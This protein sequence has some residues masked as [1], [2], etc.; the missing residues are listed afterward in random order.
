MLSTIIPQLRMLDGW[1]LKVYCM[2]LL[3][4]MF[5]TMF[6]LIPNKKAVLS[7]R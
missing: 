2:Q 1:P 3:T 4:V 6:D 7:Q 5:L